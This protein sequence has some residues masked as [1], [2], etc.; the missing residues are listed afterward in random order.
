MASM[1]ARTG[2]VELALSV[3]HQLFALPLSAAAQCYIAVHEALTQAKARRLTLAL[4]AF[5]RAAIFSEQTKNEAA[6]SWLGI[7]DRSFVERMRASVLAQF[8]NIEAITLLERLDQSTPAAFQRYRVHLATDV[9]LI[10]AHQKQ[11]EPSAEALASAVL[12]NR[13]IRS[14]EKTRRIYAVRAL[15][16]PYRDSKAVQAVDEMI[17]ETRIGERVL[18]QPATETQRPEPT[19][20]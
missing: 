6:S 12:L 4:K 19:T 16:D 13:Q 5:D 15:L 7:P 8:G 10:H 11:V 18:G 14:V 2:G 1:H 17:R 9:A 3:L 20:R